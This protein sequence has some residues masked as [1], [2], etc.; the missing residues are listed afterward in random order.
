MTHLSLVCNHCHDNRSLEQQ[1][2]A[3]C[4]AK[5]CKQYQPNNITVN[6]C[7]VLTFLP[8][9]KFKGRFIKIN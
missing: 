3:S 1:P 4:L 7:R 5:D 9:I 2:I 8:S 6:F